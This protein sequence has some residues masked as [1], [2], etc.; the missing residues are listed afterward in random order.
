MVPLSQVV[1]LGRLL[2]LSS[3]VTHSATPCR[4]PVPEASAP[5]VEL[6]LPSAARLLEV[7]SA[8]LC[9]ALHAIPD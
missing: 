9:I 6:A 7:Y 1:L 3:E 8:C 4:V 2:L 5:L